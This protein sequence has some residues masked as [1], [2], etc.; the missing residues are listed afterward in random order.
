MINKEVIPA[1]DMLLEEMERIIPDLNQ[2]GKEL[3]DDKKYQQAHEVINKA[4]AVIKFQEKVKALRAEWVSMQVP[5]TRPIT[6]EPNK[7]EKALAHATKGLR[8]PEDNF[9]IPI[10]RAL[11]K[12]GGSASIN[13][14]MSI[15]FSEMQDVLNE[16]DRSPLKSTPNFPRWRNTAQWAR[17]ELVIDGLMKETKTYGVW[18]ISDEG[19]KFLNEIDRSKQVVHKEKPVSQLPKNLHYAI[20]VYKLMRSGAYPFKQACRAVATNENLGLINIVT[21][22]CTKSLRLTEDQFIEL[23]K[24]QQSFIYRLGYFY[25]D[26]RDE[27]AAALKKTGG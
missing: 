17:N 12:K 2:Q 20:S 27:I 14:V 15:V 7:P 21:D 11:Q 13:T 16:F 26:H 10:L 4:Q 24:N 5:Q 25:P 22:A 8:T 3:M 1:F 23:T 9:K 6:P 18:E 19:R